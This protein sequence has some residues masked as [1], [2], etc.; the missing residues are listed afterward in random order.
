MKHLTPH[1]TFLRTSV[2]LIAV[3]ALLA[4]CQQRTRL[5]VWTPSPEGLSPVEATWA[6]AKVI[7]PRQYVDGKDTLVM[8]TMTDGRVKR[9][10]ATLADKGVALPV[11]VFLHGCNGGGNTI[12]DLAFSQAD[13]GYITVAP[14]SRARP[15]RITY[16]GVPTH[17]Q[18]KAIQWR[19]QEATNALRHLQSA[20]WAKNSHIYLAGHSEGGLAVSVNTAEG[21]RARLLFG[22]TCFGARNRRV[23]APGNQPSLAIVAKRDKTL[24]A[25]GATMVPCRV[26]GHPASRSISLNSDQHQV[27]TLPAAKAA[28]HRF[29][30]ATE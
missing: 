4:G 16:C 3:T 29:M 10:L 11:I 23:S 2:L 18:G 13:H 25:A 5:T 27:A 7:I 9:A 19:N 17:P 26:N 8:G 12:W 6:T 15:N 30:R 14:D 22:T 28:I 21:F 24:R 1:S 20:P